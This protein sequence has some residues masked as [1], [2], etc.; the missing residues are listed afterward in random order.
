MRVSINPSNILFIAV[1]LCSIGKIVAMD[2]DM[3]MSDDEGADG[4]L[5]DKV[6]AVTATSDS[7]AANSLPSL[8][9]VPH[10]VM[11]HHG[12]PILETNL[13]PEERLFWEAYNTTTY[14]NVPT[15]HR[16]ALYVHIILGL[17]AM[18]IIYP[19]S[20]IFNNLNLNS[21][22][23]I[24]LT[25]HTALILISLLN[26]S[27]FIN[28]IEDLYPGN[29]YNKMT[30]ILLFS[31]IIQYVMAL[32]NFGYK[33]INNEFNGIG[34]HDKSG[35][36]N[37]SNALNDYNMLPFED[38]DDNH[39]GYSSPT[40]TLYDLSRQGTTS[41]SLDLN[42]NSNGHDM[43]STNAM[44]LP[45]SNTMKLH[46]S[47]PPPSFISK[48]FS[49][50]IFQHISSSIY[51]F[52][53]ISFNLLNWG[54]FFYYL[55][56]IPTGVAT[57][58]LYGKGSTVFNLLAHFIKGGVFFAYG[59]LSLARYSGAF[60][61][62]GWA[63]NHKFMTESNVKSSFWNRIQSRGLC[64]MEM[65]ESSLILFYGSTNVFLEH[66]ADAG[67]DWSPKDLQHVSIAFI[68]IGTGLC[69][70]ITELKLASWRYEKSI[71]NLEKYE[72][73][74]S[75]SKDQ[76]VQV[77]F[78]GNDSNHSSKKS[79][80]LTKLSSLILKA[81]PGF[82]PNPFPTVTVYWTGIIMSSHEQASEL[83]TAIHVQWGQLFVIACAFRFMTYL[84][85]LLTRA[86]IKNLLKPSRPFTE[87]IVSFGLI[88]GGLVFMESTDP[89]VLSFEYYGFTAMF[90]LNLSLGFVMLI[91]SWEMLLFAFKDWLIERYS[92][93]KYIINTSS[94]SSNV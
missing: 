34:N 20:L 49:F 10:V 83:S 21:G 11:H 13:K 88:C 75:K 54:H 58:A 16:A 65:I 91:M 44:L 19:I 15:S 40:I 25:I 38:Y 70:V 53:H 30:W 62:K 69:G 80:F 90:T 66:L 31:T 51:N 87:L 89:V 3:D 72:K 94:T 73:V 45:D 86:N 78:N 29:A 79:K 48:I 56:Y 74:N 76:K 35:N 52:S 28:S 77:H 2:M 92:N 59:L 60:Q 22:Y 57:F 33:Y 37:S 36:N 43:T 27:I 5:P 55:V 18:T 24:T 8:I 82:S 71:E 12:L 81:S 63:W 14:Y 32:I 50:S 84:L 46:Q 26:Y 47:S 6:S 42:E 85:M 4:M 61:A 1:L 68:Y 9:P 41:N 39:S 64:T 67:Q 17:I 93:K 7:N 23:L